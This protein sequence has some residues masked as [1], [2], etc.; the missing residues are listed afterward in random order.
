VDVKHK[1][2]AEGSLP[3]DK[4]SKWVVEAI[5]VFAT[6]EHDFVHFEKIKRYL[7]DRMTREKIVVVSK[8]TKRA[9]FEAV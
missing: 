2:K 6:E 8:L 7:C 4:Y 9:L 3:Q 5:I 1:S